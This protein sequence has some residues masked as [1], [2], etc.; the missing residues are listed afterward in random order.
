MT[1]SSKAARTPPKRAFL[2]HE[3]TIGIDGPVVAFAW[4]AH[5]FGQLDEALVERQ[6][7]AHRVL[8]ALVGA[9]EE[10]EMGLQVLIN[11]V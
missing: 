9:L 11:L 8:P 3:L 4:L 10:R 2:E 5:R 7:V 1:L 6:V